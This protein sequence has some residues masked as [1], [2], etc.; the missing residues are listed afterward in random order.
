VQDIIRS[1]TGHFSLAFMT[2]VIGLPSA[3][4]LRAL[5]LITEARHEASRQPMGAQS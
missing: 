4:A 2:T 3:A 1:L 5:L